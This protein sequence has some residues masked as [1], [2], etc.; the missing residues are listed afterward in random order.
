MKVSIGILAHD[1]ATSIEQTL[2]SLF[3][4]TI[5]ERPVTIEVVVLPNGCSD[6]TAEIAR[7]ALAELTAKQREAE[8]SHAVFELA[9]GGKSAAWNVF[10]H[11]SSR[12]DADYLVLMDAD[13]EMHHR[14]TLENLVGALVADP[15]ARVAVDTAI[16]DLQLRPARTLIEVL[17]VALT[18]SYEGE[19]VYICGQLYCGRASALRR[20]WLPIG[21]PVE[22]GFLFSMVTRDCFTEPLQRKRVIRAANASHV[23][24]AYTRVEQLLHH[25]K[26]IIIGMAINALLVEHFKRASSP[27]RHA[28]VLIREENQRDPHWLGAFVQRGLARKGLWVLPPAWL[29]RRFEGLQRKPLTGAVL[30]APAMLAVTAV[31][32]Y[33]QSAANLQLRRGQVAGFW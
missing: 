29:L 19:P 31:D 7:S 25:E 16:K 20:I 14:E 2:R 26:R 4:Q 13:I 11:Q 17:S 23:F 24:K 18:N 8:V 30:L 22:D 5:F 27:E 32:L 33:V 12:P 1:E 28:G 6:A 21:L 3:A 10:V 15:E 9:E